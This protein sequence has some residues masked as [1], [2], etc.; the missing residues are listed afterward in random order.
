MYHSTAILLR[1]GCVLVGGSNPH[2]K[3]EFTGV[4]YPTEIS[5]EAFSP[6]YLDPENSILCPKIVLTASQTKLKYKQKLV[7]RFTV[8]GTVAIDKV[9]V[10]MWLCR[11][12]HTPSL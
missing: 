6:A 9:S 7:V 8:A 1:D 3:Y 12:Q 2:D 11:S 4:P 10:T 5:L